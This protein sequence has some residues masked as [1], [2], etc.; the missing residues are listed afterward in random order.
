MFGNPFYP[1]HFCALIPIDDEKIDY[2]IQF[3]ER[4]NSSLDLSKNIRESPIRKKAK[5]HIRQT[6][7]GFSIDIYQ[8]QR[9]MVH[10]QN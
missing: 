7:I 3:Y 6:Q 9:K 4:H 2:S 8:R 10:L 1:N 5:C